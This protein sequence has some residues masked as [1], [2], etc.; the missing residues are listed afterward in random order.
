MKANA[1]KE[2]EHYNQVSSGIN[3]NKEDI[4]KQQLINEILNR[5]VDSNFEQAQEA[6]SEVDNKLQ[7][8]EKIME[9]R[10]KT[11]IKIYFTFLKLT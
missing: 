1:S 6:F 11:F 3:K 9:Y 2:T 7:T 10:I 5:R 8:L 4:L